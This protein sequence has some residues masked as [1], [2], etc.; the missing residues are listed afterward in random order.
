MIFCPMVSFFLSSFFSATLVSVASAAFLSDARAE[1][2]LLSSAVAAEDLEASFISALRVFATE[3]LDKG[4]GVSSLG[5]GC[6]AFSALKPG[7]GGAAAPPPPVLVEV[8]V[9]IHRVEAMNARG[10]FVYEGDVTR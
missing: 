4:D 10:V 2:V 3:A 9:D 1:R 8:S 5:S 7:G 6:F